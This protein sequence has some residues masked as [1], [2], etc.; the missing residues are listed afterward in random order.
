M[1]KRTDF[2]ACM[3]LAGG[4]LQCG[5]QPKPVGSP[6]HGSS[7]ASEDGDT[8]T[9]AETTVAPECVEQDQDGDGLPDT[10]DACPEKLGAIQVQEPNLLGCPMRLVMR[11][12]NDVRYLTF[13]LRLC[14]DVNG[15]PES[16]A[17]VLTSFGDMFERE[18]NRPAVEVAAWVMP[19]PNR[20][21]RLA[22]ARSRAVMVRDH[23]LSAGAPREKVGIMLIDPKWEYPVPRYVNR[24]DVV[25]P[26][27]A[28]PP[29]AVMLEKQTAEKQ[30]PQPAEASVD[31]IERLPLIPAAVDSGTRCEAHNQCVLDIMHFSQDVECSCPR[32]YAR[33][34][35]ESPSPAEAQDVPSARL[36]TCGS[37]PPTFGGGRHEALCVD[38]R[39]TL[40]R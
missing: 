12:W 15:L 40:V 35:S 4:V 29:Q 34:E 24:V 9:T 39:C 10:F 6:E 32:P 27:A 21:I 19:G 37:C 3:L 14:P 17:G 36:Q 25:G 23:I 20:G 1:R 13:S 16:T 7:G 26:V 2:V 30:A 8:E 31:P 28:N 11:S 5:P 33:H 18:P 38:G 22:E